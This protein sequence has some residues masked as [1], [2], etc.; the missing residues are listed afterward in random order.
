MKQLE[1]GAVKK[2]WTGKYPIALVYPNKYR[3]GMGNLAVHYLYSRLNSYENIVCERVFLPEKKGDPVRSIEGNH[4]LS[5]FKA[6]FISVSFENDFENVKNV[7]A[8][9]RERAKQSLVMVG[10]P[11]VTINPHT[12][13]DVVDAI[14]IG[15]CDDKIDDIV[16]ALF[17][18]SEHSEESVFIKNRS[19]AYAQDDKSK[20]L[21]KLSHI[22]GMYVPS[23]SKKIP[24]RHYV[25]NLD[26]YLVHTMIDSPDA[27]FGDMF[28]IEMGRGCPF[29][30]KFCTVPVIYNPYRSRSLDALWKMVEIGL[31]QG[32]RIGLVSP[33]ILLNKKFK[34]LAEK[35]IEAGGEFSTSSI[36]AD[37]VNEEN[38]RL[39]FL[40]G[41]KSVSV[42]VETGNENKRAGL[43][44]KI[45]NSTIIESAVILSNAG[46]K[47]IKLYFMDGIPNETEDDLTSIVELSTEVKD[48]SKKGTKIEVVLSP[49]VPKPGTFF[50]NEKFA[51][52]KYLSDAYNFIRPRLEKLGI[53]V[54]GRTVKDAEKE[55]SYGILKK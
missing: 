30:C 55:Y 43:G 13:E 36:R 9:E 12:L 8:S 48:S 37:Q 26:E 44:K 50:E 49:F 23:I 31:K 11:A 24:K 10:G 15:E 20:E 14:F 22:D 4:Q 27:E 40:G 41:M 47:K 34:P 1:K 16:D 17:C 35:I 39:L 54:S 6:I 2:K 5:D 45:K 21:E 33:D 32:K 52:K 29:N 19:F 28:L 7:I 53:K 51:G 38:A 46:I 3:V 25:K 42:G 18:H